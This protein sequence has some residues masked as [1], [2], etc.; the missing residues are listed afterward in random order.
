M[1]IENRLNILKLKKIIIRIIEMSM[2][3]VTVITENKNIIYTDCSST[4][5]I[6]Q[7]MYRLFMYCRVVHLMHRLFMY[8]RDSSG[9]VQFVH[10]L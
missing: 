2:Y 3:L 7:L 5:E 4:V 9:N 8:C 1:Q 10:V 6:V